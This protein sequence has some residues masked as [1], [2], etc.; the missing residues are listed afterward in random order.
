MT[1]TPRARSLNSR[2]GKKEIAK[3]KRGK[4]K[5]A[6][7]EKRAYGTPDSHVVPHRSTDEACSGL[8][9]QFGRDTV[10]FTEYGRRHSAP[11]KRQYMY[12]RLTRGLHAAG[13]SGCC[14]Q[15]RRHRPRSTLAHCLHSVDAGSVDATV[16]RT[17]A[18]GAA[19]E[20]AA[21]GR[22]CPADANFVTGTQVPMAACVERS[23]SSTQLFA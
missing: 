18:A 15:S 17:P 4:K 16:I 10:R 2:R 22:S 5:K 3:A 7:K 8:T 20:P 11:C 6:K 23:A 21:S 1:R 19:R 13:G 9:A 12:C 14:P